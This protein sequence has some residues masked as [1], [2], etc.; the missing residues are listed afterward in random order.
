L[1]G[2]GTSFLLDTLLS[3]RLRTNLAQASVRGA[4]ADFSESIWTVRRDLRSA[5]LALVVAER[6]VAALE[7]DSR[8]RA[9]LLRLTQ[10]RIAAGESARPEGL[11]AQLEMSRT[12]AALEDARRV[13][14]DA[15]AKLGA[16]IGVTADALDGIAPEWNDLEDLAPP[17]ES[18]A[19]LRGQALLS[20]PD[21]ER[22]IADYSAREL[23]LRQQMSAQYLQASLG[24]GYTYDH[25]IRKVTFGASV[26]VPI[27]NHNE[28][29]IAEA[30]AARETAGRHAM[31]VQASVLNEIE[32][33]TQAYS[34]ALSALERARAQRD[35]S[36]SV[37]SAARRAFEADGSDR[38]TLL[39]AE[40]AASTERL[41]ELDALDRA[42]QALGQLEDAVRAPLLG[43]E[44]RLRL[45]DAIASPPPEHP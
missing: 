34:T 26:S 32:A 17:P 6:R 18:L 30:M 44:T 42:Q 22:A 45:S 38:P 7:T 41:A 29:P 37:A 25:G 8:Q 36:E 3:R 35:S 15:R 9:E 24:P 27:F 31:A 10:A 16:A 33:A 28:G 21:L 39:T 1:W 20:R 5:L 43:P 4:H 2:V 14:G 12:Q 23:D 40:L 13:R 11:Q 19:T